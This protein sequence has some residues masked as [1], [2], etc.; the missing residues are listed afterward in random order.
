MYDFSSMIILSMLILGLAIGS[1]ISAS[2]W[3]LHEQ[4][5]LVIAKKKPN[6]SLS[7]TRGRSM[8]EHCGH[9]LA[10]KDLIPLFSWIGL[11]GRCQYCKA[12]LSWEYPVVELV[13]AVIFVLSYMAWDFGDTFGYVSFG[14]WL[15][16]L[17]A[18]IFLALYDLKWLLLPNRVVYPMIIGATI[19]VIIES[20]FFGGGIDVIKDS[21]VGMFFAGGIFYA[22][23]AVSKGRWIGGG[24]VKLGIFIGI[25]LGLSRSILTF[26]LAFNVAAI[27]ILPLLLLGVV[28]RKTPIP[29]GPFLIFATIISTL[30]G[31]EIIQW[32]SD[33]FLY[34]VI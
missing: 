28:K 15:V 12:K 20:V 13:T 25:F 18:L 11:Q 4:E 1:F 10:P 31:Y 3:R 21:A 14:F 2:V 5:E 19:L 24:D 34:G 22:L 23:F 7:I 16:F 6:K 8:C 30:Y 29:F 27:I 17:S 9:T 32:Y 26:I 33:N